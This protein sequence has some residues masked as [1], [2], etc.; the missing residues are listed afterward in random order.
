VLVIH[1]QA[2]TRLDR[3]GAVAPRSLPGRLERAHDLTIGE[4]RQP[5][6]AIDAADA[7]EKN[8]LLAVV[9]M[10]ALHL[11][12][13]TVDAAKGCITEQRARTLAEIK[14]A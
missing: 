13:L 1:A 4:K 11:A 8:D 6:P 12:L 10:K 9:A 14:D 2:I 3:A 5:P 7:L